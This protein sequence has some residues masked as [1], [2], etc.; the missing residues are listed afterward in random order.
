MSVDE[1]R[2]AIAEKRV[3]R[4]KYN[5]VRTQNEDG[6]WSDSKREARIDRDIMALR[7]SPLTKRVTR[8]QRFPLIVRSVL[9]GTY[10]ADWTRELQCG[11][12]EV[13]DAKGCRTKEYLK[14][15]KLMKEI[16]GVEIIEL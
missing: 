1:Y 8:K 13:Y 7:L 6:T 5:A 11:T 12:I 4:H 9:I 15:K 2:A 10:E 14:K 16:Y 3:R